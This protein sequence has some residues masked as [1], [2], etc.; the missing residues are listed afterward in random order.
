MGQDHLYKMTRVMEVSRNDWA[1]DRF[2]W[3]PFRTRGVRP[4]T[5]VRARRHMLLT[6]LGVRACARA[7]LTRRRRPRQCWFVIV[8]YTWWVGR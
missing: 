5:C 8:L 4:L 2:G 6:A 7:L 1:G 3:Q